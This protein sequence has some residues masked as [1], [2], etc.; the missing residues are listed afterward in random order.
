LGAGFTAEQQ[1]LLRRI[2]FG[3]ATF[4]FSQIKS[5]VTSYALVDA[6]KLPFAEKQARYKKVRTKISRLFDSR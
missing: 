4:V 2:H 1:S 5:A 3:A 6:K